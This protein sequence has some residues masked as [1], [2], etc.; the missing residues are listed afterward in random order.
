MRLA[1][2]LTLVALASACAREEPYA[3]DTPPAPLEAEPPLGA[4]G[5]VVL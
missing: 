3:G 2:L 1:L 4:Y 5:P